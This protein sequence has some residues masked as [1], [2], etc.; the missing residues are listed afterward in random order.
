MRL[1]WLHSLL[2]PIELVELHL[3]PGLVMPKLDAVNFNSNE[4]RTQNQ[5]DIG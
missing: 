3:I 1:S 4:M 2:V 5:S